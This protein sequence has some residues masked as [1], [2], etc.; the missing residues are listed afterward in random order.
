[1]PS[2][3]HK[4]VDYLKRNGIKSTYY[5]VME[6]LTPGG[7][8]DHNGYAYVPPSPEELEKQRLAWRQDEHPVS[9]SILVPAYETK[10]EYL[11]AL[12]DSVQAQ[13]WGEWELIIADA[14][15]SDSVEKTVALYQ[16]DA[17]IRYYRLERNGGISE[18]TN[19]ALEKAE[20]MYVGLLDHD[21]LLTPDALFEMAQ[22]IRKTKEA[23]LVYS[24]EDKCDGLGHYF[25]EPH[26]KEKF[27]LDLFLTNN[28]VCHFMAIE[29]SLFKRLRLRSDYDGAQDYDV[30]LRV[31]TEIR[32]E[33]FM[34][35]ERIAHVSKVLYHWR[36]HSQSTAENPKSKRYAYEA[37]R[38]AV[39]DFLK[40]NDM[41]ANVENLTH[42]GF[43]RVDYGGEIWRE[44]PDIALIGGK[45][46]GRDNKITSGILSENGTPLYAGLDAH[47]SGY[48]HRAALQQDAAAVD[49]RCMRVRRE[50]L[51]LFKQYF[52]VASPQA[53]CRTDEEKDWIK[54][55]MEFCGFIRGQMP[56]TR[57]LWDPSWVVKL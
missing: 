42:L 34:P 7:M 21:D 38:R 13:S 26:L 20:K 36:C 6:R 9:F 11:S 46:L 15:T 2:Y 33:G 56:R 22:T 47:Y 55:S 41:K 12:I 32:K 57:F 51:P 17:R 45:I 39:G 10:R 16:E 18:N 1:M 5:A 3:I 4:T 48:L 29:R 19:K 27:N 28:Y 30:A 14:G 31:V 43:Y 49:V 52:G 54:I 44:R 40:E 23:A 37:G 50:L 8:A 53:L 35:E 25:Y 24:D